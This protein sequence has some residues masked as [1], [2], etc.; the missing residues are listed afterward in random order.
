VPAAIAVDDLC[1]A[2]TACAPPHPAAAEGFSE[3]LTAG[4]SNAA[5]IAQFRQT[6]A[7]LAEVKARLRAADVSFTD[8][9]PHP[10]RR[11][12]AHALTPRGAQFLAT[13]PQPYEAAHRAATNLL[14]LSDAMLPF[15]LH[16]VRLALG[17]DL[18]LDG[19]T[20]TVPADLQVNESAPR[21]LL[22]A[23]PA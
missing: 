6:Q 20:M 7:A 9:V 22:H 18:S 4:G 21:R 13:Q 12:R 10:A 17:G 23:A 19:Y 2:L 3:E 5:N 1:T 14:R 8:E 15:A 11:A 16:G